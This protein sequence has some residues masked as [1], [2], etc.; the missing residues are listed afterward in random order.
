MIFGNPIAQSLS[1]FIHRVFSEQ[2]KQTLEYGRQCIALELFFST[3]SDF[4]NQGGKGCNITTPFKE[5]AFQFA[6]EITERAMLAGAVN[7]LKRLDSGVI[8]GDNTDGLG[9]V[10]DLERYNL[11]TSDTNLLL[12]GAGGAAKGVINP[13]LE[14]KPK[15]ITVVNRTYE[16]A[17]RLAQSFSAYGDISSIR[18]EKLSHHYD[19]VINATSADLQGSYLKV[20]SKIFSPVTVSYDMSYMKKTTSFNRLARESGVSR[21]YDGLGMLVEQAAESFRLWRGVYPEAASV[22]KLL[23]KA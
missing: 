16:K 20:P 15:S 23:M 19:L 9:L 4:F 11:I 12:I 14:A 17:K 6:D 1:P 18:F 3:V 21:T 5:L 10:K 2:T 13:L 7:T 22:F 8:L